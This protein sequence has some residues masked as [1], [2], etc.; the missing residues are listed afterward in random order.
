MVIK[1]KEQT[2]DCETK[3]KFCAKKTGWCWRTHK[4]L[5]LKKNILTVSISWAQAGIFQ[6]PLQKGTVY[7]AKKCENGL[8]TTRD[9][10]NEGNGSHYI[11]EDPT[12][13]F[14]SQ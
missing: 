12:V 2:N 9:N 8:P 7:C 11:S 5:K 14:Q 1:H 3:H 4:E 6:S 13:R 10:M